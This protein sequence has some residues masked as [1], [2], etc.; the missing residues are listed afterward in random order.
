MNKIL[1]EFKKLFKD[2]RKIVLFEE[3]IEKD[4]S[5]DFLRKIVVFFMV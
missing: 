3:F 5:M 4:V 1:T 2:E